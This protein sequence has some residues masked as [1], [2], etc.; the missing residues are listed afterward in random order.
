MRKLGLVAKTTA[1]S[2]A[3]LACKGAPEPAPPEASAP[4]TAAVP[5]DAPNPP[6]TP[7]SAAGSNAG[8]SG[9]RVVGEATKTI[10][11]KKGERFGVA[12]ESNVT[13]PFKWRLDPPDAKVLTLVEEKQ[14]ETPPPGCSDC[15]GTGG[16]KVFVFEAKDKGTA[17]L[18]FALKPLTDPAAP[19]QK[20][21]TVSVTVGE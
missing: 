14:H 10:S 7:A 11:L 4:A 8:A 18:H 5:N 20:E 16:T 21:V 19:A 15:V 17:S 12:L 6:S 3:M 13:L 2:L 9:V 1:L